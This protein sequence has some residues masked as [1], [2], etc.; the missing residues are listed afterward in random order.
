VRASVWL[1]W[2]IRT[3]SCCPRRMV[4]DYMASIKITEQDIAAL[5]A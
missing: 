1:A 5:I 4:E 2:R 3:L